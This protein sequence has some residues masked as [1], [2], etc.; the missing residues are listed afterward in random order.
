MAVIPGNGLDLR[1]D[2]FSEVVTVGRI[3]RRQHL[4]RTIELCS[5]F[6]RHGSAGSCAKDKHV[7]Q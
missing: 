4:C 1:R 5:F 3:I 7:D 2:R 6:R